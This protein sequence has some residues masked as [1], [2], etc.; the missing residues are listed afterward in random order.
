MVSAHHLDLSSEKNKAM[1][2]LLNTS[3]VSFTPVRVCLYCIVLSCLKSKVELDPNDS[4][5][6]LNDTNNGISL[7]SASV[8]LRAAVH[9]EQH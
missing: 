4:P 5:V 1:Q 7:I 6:P 3:R 9:L 8:R 2:S